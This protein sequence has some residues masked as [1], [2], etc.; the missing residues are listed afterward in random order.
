MITDPDIACARS[1]KAVTQEDGRARGDEPGICFCYD[2]QSAESA[3]KLMEE[4]QIRGGGFRPKR[5]R[6]RIVSLGDLAV[7]NQDDR[8]SGEVLGGFQSR[9][10]QNA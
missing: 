7:R 2:D 8:L 10:S 4:K 1:P 6:H 3:A 5:A 9:A